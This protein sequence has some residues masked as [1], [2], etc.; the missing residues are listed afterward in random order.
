MLAEGHGRTMQE[1]ADRSGVG[2]TTLYRRFRTREDLLRAIFEQAIAEARDGIAAAHP[3]EGDAR[4]AMERVIEELL[5]IGDKYRVLFQETTA[6]SEQIDG[7]PDF[8]DDLRDL[9]VRAQRAGVVDGLMPVAWVLE[10]MGALVCTAARLIGTG[11]LARN[12]AADL[13]TRTLLGG[14]G[15]QGN[16][17]SRR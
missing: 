2:R 16:E 8:V 12:H 14:V 11:E 3:A 9:V 1:I 15:V 10:M 17:S 7:E 13:V 4:E 6:R 5:K